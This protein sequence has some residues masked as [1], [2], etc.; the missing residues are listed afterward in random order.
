MIL[1]KESSFTDWD[2]R[3]NFGG[4]VFLKEAKSYFCLGHQFG[5]IQCLLFVVYCLVYKHSI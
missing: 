2:D 5:D 3:W 4:V 1:V